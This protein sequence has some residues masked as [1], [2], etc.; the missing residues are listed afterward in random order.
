MAAV[1]GSLTIAAHALGGLAL[2]AAGIGEASGMVAKV[3]VVGEVLVVGG[4]DPGR[5]WHDYKGA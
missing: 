4:D 5:R 1:A 2:V 3:Q